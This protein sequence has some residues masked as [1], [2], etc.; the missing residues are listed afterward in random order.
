VTSG[1]DET[2]LYSIAESLRTIAERMPSVELQQRIEVV[3]AD[4]DEAVREIR[5]LVQ[6]KADLEA[7]NARLEEQ[8]MRL[9]ENGGR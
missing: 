9:Q 2:Y 4:Y 5:R 6:V 1:R 8:V 3:K 7:E